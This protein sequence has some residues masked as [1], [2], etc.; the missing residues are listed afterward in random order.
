MNQSISWFIH[1]FFCCVEE[2]AESEENW[3]EMKRNASTIPRR[4]KLNERESVRYSIRMIHDGKSTRLLY[5]MPGRQKGMGDYDVNYQPSAIDNSTPLHFTPPFWSCME[6]ATSAENRSDPMWLWL[7]VVLFIVSTAHSRAAE[8]VDWSPSS[9]W[10]MSGRNIP[11]WLLQ[12]LQS[13]WSQCTKRTNRKT[14]E[15]TNRVTISSRNETCC[16]A[17]VIIVFV[18]RV[19]WS[20]TKTVAVR[21]S[22]CCCYCGLRSFTIS[23]PAHSV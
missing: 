8:P 16:W 15:R 14:N 11:W 4:K 21:R 12:L 7:V 20:I 23:G 18:V 2:E 9:R 1:F 19:Y 3:N 10:N 5:A 6:A 22:S 13:E 17:V